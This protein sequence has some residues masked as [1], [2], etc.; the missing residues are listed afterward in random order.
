MITICNY[1][2]LANKLQL[3]NRKENIKMY[4]ENITNEYKIISNQ[5]VKLEKKNYNNPRRRISNL[6]LYLYILL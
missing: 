4:N 5:N 6:L 3:T 2:R 1:N